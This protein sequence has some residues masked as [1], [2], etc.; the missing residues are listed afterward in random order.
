METG[1]GLIAAERQR[2][3]QAEGYD[4]EHDDQHVHRELLITAWEILGVFHPRLEADA[5]DDWGLIPRHRRRPG[6]ELRLLVIAGALVAAEIDRL[7]RA[8][9]EGQPEPID[10]ELGPLIVDLVVAA[11]ETE[12][13]ADEEAER[14]L[15]EAESEL[16]AYVAAV[17]EAW[18]DDVYEKDAEIAALRE[19]KEDWKLAAGERMAQRGRVKWFNSVKGFGFIVPDAGGAECFV[20]HSAIEGTGFR[21]LEEGDHVEFEIEQSEKGPKAGHVRVVESVVDNAGSEHRVH[22]L[23]SVELRELASRA[24]EIA[25]EHEEMSTEAAADQAI[26]ENVGT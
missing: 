23:T 22:R 5:D 7:L 11:Q 18:A 19:E 20:H 16:R 6:G 25:R 10:E 17:H 21:A 26:H 13:I 12:T 24:A 14:Q 4:A 9:K 8:E 2:Q 3:I 15:H 1:I